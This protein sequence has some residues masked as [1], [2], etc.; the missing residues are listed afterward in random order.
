MELSSQGFHHTFPKL[1]P[2]CFYIWRLG[3]GEVIRSQGRV[4]INVISS[5]I[6]ETTESF[7][8]PFIVG[9][10]VKK[11]CCLSHPLNSIFVTVARVD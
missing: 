9:G 10:T 1:N 3:F 4:L 11:K 6:K 2:Q 5:L 7:I 8:A